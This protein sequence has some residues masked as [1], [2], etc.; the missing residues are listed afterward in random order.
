M[1]LENPSC[2]IMFGGPLTFSHT[3]TTVTS[4]NPHHA[5]PNPQHHSRAH[6][7]IPETNIRSRPR[8]NIP[9]L[10]GPNPIACNYLS[11]V[12]VP[13]PSLP[14]IRYPYLYFVPSV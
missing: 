7:L 14:H 10:I 9:D 1:R 12:L 4:C 13:C 6:K 5:F 11:L 3:V 8:L 2:F